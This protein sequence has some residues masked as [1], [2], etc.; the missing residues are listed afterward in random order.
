MA[1]PKPS[2]SESVPHSSSPAPRS[3]FRVPSSRVLIVDDEESIRVTLAE[4]IKDERYEVHTAADADEALRLIDDQPFDVV[5]TDIVLPRVSG[6]ALLNEIHKRRPDTQVIMITGDPTVETAVEAVRAGAFDYLTKPVSKSAINRAIANAARVKSMTDEKRRLEEEKRRYQK[7]LQDLV[8]ERTKELQESEAHYR[9]IVQ[10][11][12]ECIDRWLPN[13]TLT[14]VNDAY[15]Q[16][17]GKSREEL[18]G[19]NWIESV[20][21]ED[22]DQ[23]REYVEHL[24]KAVSPESPVLSSEHREVVANG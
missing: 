19:C 12:T 13:G 15:C 10:Y 7:H 5:V 14:F 24:K 11:Q 8:D 18:I 23:M 21:R 4:F 16:Y 6:V 3:E 2:N 1:N 20:T 9:G 17:Y 22:R